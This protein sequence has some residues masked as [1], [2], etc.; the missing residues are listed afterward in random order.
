MVQIESVKGPIDT[1]DLGFTL[2]HEHVVVSSAGIPQIYPEFIQ[3]EKSIKEGIRTLRAAKA[4]GLDSIIDVTTL[5]LGRDIDMLKQVSEG[6][7]VNIVCATGT[8]RDIPRAFWS[9]TSDSVA[10]LYTREIT[11]GIEGTDIKAGIIK[12]ANDVGGVT[13]EGEIILRAAARAQKQTG[14]PISTHTWAPDRVGEQQVR[15]FEDEK[16]DL[17]R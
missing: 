8:W 15:I 11:V 3:R 12:V 9:A 5:D 13:R 16:I 2:S 1:S 4:E 6:S 10:E 14:V 17:S 7:G